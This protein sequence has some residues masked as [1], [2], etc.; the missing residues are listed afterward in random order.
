MNIEAIVAE[1]TKEVMACLNAGVGTNTPGSDLARTIE[2]SIM[3]P[4]VTRDKILEGCRDVKALGMANICVS[5]YYVPLAAELLGS[6]ALVCTAIAFPHGAATTAAK[7]TEAR[8]AIK[9]GA[10]ELDV[11]MN[12]LAIK[13][14]DLDEAR[15]DLEAVIDIAR[16][17]A[18]VKAI[19][20]QCMY[21]EKE[22]VQ[23]L[24]IAQKAGA[25]FIKI[26]NALSGKKAAAED[27]RFV[28]SIVGEGIGIKIDGG[29]SDAGIIRELMAAGANRFGC[30]RSVQIIKG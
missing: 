25:D 19:Y 30:S 5:P 11:S 10:G 27:V 14:G 1:V 26:S 28:R 6:G 20:E 23:A 16:G 15:R 17:R 3:N 13:N 12:I 4:D 21:S 7:V 8:E 9:N 22:S 18:R 24:E 2:H 29:I